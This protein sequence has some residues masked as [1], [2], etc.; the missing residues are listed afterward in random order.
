MHTVAHSSKTFFAICT[1][2]MQGLAQV[3]SKSIVTKREKC[4][5]IT[6]TNGRT[7]I[8]MQCISISFNTQTNTQKTRQRDK[9]EEKNQHGSWT[10]PIYP[11]NPAILYEVIT[12]IFKQMNC[13]N[14]L[15]LNQ[16]YD[17][18]A[19][20]WRCECIHRYCEC[21]KESEMSGCSLYQYNIFT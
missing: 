6:T 11:Y 9:N 21:V 10:L 19:R 15:Q 16:W 17:T 18:L 14:T 8:H 7:K 12:F 4:E 13:T 3:Q 2:L 20:L 1:L 5:T